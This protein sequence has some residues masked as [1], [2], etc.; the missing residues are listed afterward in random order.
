VVPTEVVTG[1]GAAAAAAGG[2]MEA[3]VG[4]DSVAAG[5]VA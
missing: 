4:V 5:V 1:L 2:S 3:A